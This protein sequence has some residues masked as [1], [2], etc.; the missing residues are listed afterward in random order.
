MLADS[1]TLKLY[2]EKNG[3]KGVCVHQNA[4]GEKFMCVV[5]AIGRRYCYIRKASGGDW[6]IRISAYWDDSK[7]CCD[8]TD[9]DIRR[10]I[11]FA[12]T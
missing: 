12:A 4:N 1:P 2:N 10:N 7:I 6:K 3:W 11:K 5:C 9:E 8:I